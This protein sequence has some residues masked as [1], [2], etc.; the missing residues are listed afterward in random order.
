MTKQEILD[1]LKFDMELRNMSASTIHDYIIRVRCFQDHFDKPADQMGEREIQE[2]LHHLLH[3]RKINPSSVNT[4]NA[5]IRFVYIHTLDININLRKIPRVKMHR[6]FPDLPTKAELQKIFDSAPSL[7]Y[8]AIFMT[9]YGSGLRISEAANLRI[10]DIDSKNMRIIIKN[11]KGKRDRYAMLPEATLHVLRDYYKQCKPK[12]WL[13]WTRNKNKMSTRS[14]QQAFDSAM[15]KS[16]INKHI[17]LHT[18]RHAFATHLLESGVNLIAIKQLLGHV[19]LD[20]TAWYARLA[21]SDVLKLQ[22]PIDA[23]PKKRSRPR[24]VKADD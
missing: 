5:S 21:D 16:G 13:F 3:T 1:K 8:R 18:L 15:K 14:I 20:T 2:Y 6:N 17:T 22:S 4:H 23:M 11:G 19:R 12:E 9:I 10:A 7:K 24:K